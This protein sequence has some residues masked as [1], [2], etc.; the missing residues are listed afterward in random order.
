MEAALVHVVD[1]FF[2]YFC[3]SNVPQIPLVGILR[4]PFVVAFSFGFHLLL[5]MEYA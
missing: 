5:L 1:F 4:R 3:P 2:C